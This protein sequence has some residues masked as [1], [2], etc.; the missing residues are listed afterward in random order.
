M[1]NAS[2]LLNS[3]NRL[4]DKL[5]QIN[6]VEL[7]LSLLHAELKLMFGYNLVWLYEF[8]NN[9]KSQIRLISVKGERQQ[10]IEQTYPVIDI[11]EDQMFTNIFSS[12]KPVYLEDARIDNTPNQKMVEAWGNRTLINS[13]LFIHD[14]SLGA[15]GTGSFN[16]EG[17]KPLTKDEIAYFGTISNVLAIALDRIN[18]KSM[19]MQ[20]PLTGLDNKR[21][22]KINADSILALAKR[23]HQKAGVIFIDLDNFKPVNDTYAHHFGDQILK[24]FADGLSRILRRSDIKAR[25]GGDEFVLI[26]PSIT[27]D[28]SIKKVIGEINTYCTNLSVD[29]IHYQL[30]FSA[31]WAVYPYDGETI[32][33][34][35]EHADSR[36]YS[37]KAASKFDY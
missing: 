30:R 1:S 13:Q 24:L 31:G 25:Y 7:M 8:L 20:D 9:R 19:S 21:S 6:S 12:S 16:D 23:N 14:K 27:D 28:S 5:Y 2:E 15:F 22:L 3:I 34:L 29:E 26:L 11:R 32:I 17:V 10:H 37:D 4:T 18:Y 36:M 35:I 33:E